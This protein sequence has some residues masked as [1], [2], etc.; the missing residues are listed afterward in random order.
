MKHKYIS[1]YI[2]IYR[3]SPIGVALTT[4]LHLD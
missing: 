2:S 3:L 1:Y 4:T